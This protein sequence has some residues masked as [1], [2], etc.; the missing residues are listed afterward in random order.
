MSQLVIELPEP[1]DQQLAESGVDQQQ[2]QLVVSRFLQL[3]LFREQMVDIK[4][5]VENLLTPSDEVNNRPRFG[6]G[7][8]LNITISEDFDEPL[9]DFAEYMQ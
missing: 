3:Y 1:L 6:S 4:S 9:E 5:Q 2:L 8:H 7:K